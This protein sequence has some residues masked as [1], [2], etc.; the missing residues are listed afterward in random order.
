MLPPHSILVAVDFSEPSRDALAF[1]ARLARQC[2][3]KLH[4]LHAEEPLLAAAA[5]QTGIDL[6]RETRE[7]LDA[8]IN[9]TPPAAECAPCRDVV[10]GAAITA[11]LN[12]AHREGS[13]LIVLGAHG[14]SMTARTFFGS[15]TEGVLERADRSTL[16]V[17]SGW[18]PPQPDMPGLAGV[19]PLIVAVDFTSSA[20]AAAV[21]ASHLAERLQTAV[22]AVHVVPDLAVPAR[23]RPHADRVA[24]EKTEVARRDLARLMGTIASP[25][26]ITTHVESGRV[27]ERLA[28]L[29]APIGSRHPMLV[30]GRRGPRFRDGAPGSTAFRVAALSRVPVLM[31][32]ET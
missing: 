31:H 27:A 14:M 5:A 18:R 29:A 4:V 16:V 26:P 25:V 10:T 7:E 19:G 3:A 32:V 1:A 24:A 13:D 2:D 11:I 23:W 17:P 6:N 21:A 20:I 8:F 22:E 15:V 30:L 28:E 9:A 12:I